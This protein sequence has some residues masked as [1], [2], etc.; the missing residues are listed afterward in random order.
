MQI[1]HTWVEET[2][3]GFM[4][5]KFL[6]HLTIRGALT[7][8]ELAAI[9]KYK[10]MN[11]WMYSNRDEREAQKARPSASANW[12]EHAAAGWHNA[13]REPLLEISMADLL[14]GVEI[15]NE[16]PYYLDAVFTEISNN[17]TKLLGNLFDLDARFSGQENVTEVFASP[18][19]PA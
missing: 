16:N 8:D 9:Q 19:Q 4:S 17:C 5:E 2:K 10:V 11:A 15:K 6:Y 7:K 14:R 12:W 1:K 13:G 3:Q 18:A